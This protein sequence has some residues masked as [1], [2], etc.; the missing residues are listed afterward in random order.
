M[1]DKKLDLYGVT[2]KGIILPLLLILFTGCEKLDFEETIVQ[3]PT[4]WGEW[5]LNETSHVYVDINEVGND[6]D[7]SWINL[8]DP[9]YIALDTDLEFDLVTPNI[10]TWT[11][12]EDMSVMVN[13]EDL[14]NISRFIYPSENLNPY[15]QCWDVNQNGQQDYFEDINGDGIC[16]VFDCS[17]PGIV[18]AVGN[19]LR[20]FEV[21]E[22]TNTSLILKFEGQYFEDF[23]Y[24]TTVLKFNKR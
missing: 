3:V 7:T 15:T 24:Y 1:K 21:T 8:N 12:N 17:P 23:D 20:A 19:T 10:T 14:Y 18:I 13:N 2:L 6:R 11:L 22:L 5:E 16:D 4:L 9:T